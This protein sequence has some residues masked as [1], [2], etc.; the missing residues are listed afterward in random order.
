MLEGA[1]TIAARAI[2]EPCQRDSLEYFRRIASQTYHDCELPGAFIYPDLW[3]AIQNGGGPLHTS[4]QDVSDY[5][6]RRPLF[7]DYA[8]SYGHEL[9]DDFVHENVIPRMNSEFLRIHCPGQEPVDGLYSL[10]GFRFSVDSLHNRFEEVPEYIVLQ[11]NPWIARDYRVSLYQSGRYFDELQYILSHVSG[12]KSEKIRLMLELGKAI[13]I[14]KARDGGEISWWMARSDNSD[15]DNLN[16]ITNALKLS[17]TMPSCYKPM[18]LLAFQKSATFYEHLRKSP[19][20]E[21]YTNFM[22]TTYDFVRE[23]DSRMHIDLGPEHKD[24]VRNG[25]FRYFRTLCYHILPDLLKSSMNRQ[26]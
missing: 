10:N 26:D 11:D 2:L 4:A 18:A 5:C 1:H 25:D 7:E 17:R 16:P 20:N 8:Y 23:Y 13:N 19:F 15:N 24:L 6:S 3:D 12:I 14:H 21:G 9:V 22:K